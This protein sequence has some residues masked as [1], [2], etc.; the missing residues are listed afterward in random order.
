MPKSRRKFLRLLIFAN[1]LLGRVS[2]KET[3]VQ[4][5]ESLKKDFFVITFFPSDVQR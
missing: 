1:L 3:E 4:K 5:A 2:A